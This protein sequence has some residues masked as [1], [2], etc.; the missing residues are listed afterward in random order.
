MTSSNHQMQDG[1]A[2]KKVCDVITS[3]FSFINVY[4]Q[5]FTSLLQ[6]EKKIILYFKT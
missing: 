2:R 4:T 1:G 3:H 5:T 6:N